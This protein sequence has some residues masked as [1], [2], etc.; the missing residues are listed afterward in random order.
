[1]MQNL[2]LLFS[3][4]RM[5]LKDTC[6]FVHSSLLIEAEGRRKN[7]GEEGFKQTTG[8]LKVRPWNLL[9]ISRVVG[10]AVVCLFLSRQH[11]MLVF[12]LDLSESGVLGQ[13]SACQTPLPLGCQSVGSLCQPP[14]ETEL[15]HGWALSLSRE[16][17][18]RRPFLQLGTNA[19][20]E[21]YKYNPFIKRRG[22]KKG[23][24]RKIEKIVVRLKED[25]N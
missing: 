24:K 15:C 7:G 6:R 3:H 17:G 16:M 22:K 2:Y 20:F 18:G 13:K 5:C 11:F 1:M 23:K 9:E 4:T 14:G 21:L 25:L 8:R 19:G 10:R 12:F